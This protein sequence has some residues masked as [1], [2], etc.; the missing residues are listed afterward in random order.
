MDLIDAIKA[1]ELL[2]VTEV[3]GCHYDTFPVIRIDHNKARNLF[4]KAG[5]TLHLMDIGQTSRF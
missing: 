2:R 1:S 4:A 5:L 3:I